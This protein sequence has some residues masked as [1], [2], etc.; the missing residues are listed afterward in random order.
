LFKA[1]GKDIILV[2]PASCTTVI[3]GPYPYI[4]V[5]V[6]LQNTLFEAGGATASGIV[7]A[8]KVRALGDVTVVCWAGDEELWI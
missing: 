5:S 1:L 6:P 4:S 2:V 3:Q 8:L 7:A